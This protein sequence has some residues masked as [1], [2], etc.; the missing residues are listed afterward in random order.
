LEGANSKAISID[1]ALR[2]VESVLGDGAQSA[3]GITPSA[4]FDDLGLSSLDFT[5]VLV[6]LEEV[7]GG[8]VDSESI[9]EDLVTV[10][11]LTKLRLVSAAR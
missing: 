7:A 8:E 2:A 11:D 3:T 10:A 6:A 4:T 1:E 9:S 5:E